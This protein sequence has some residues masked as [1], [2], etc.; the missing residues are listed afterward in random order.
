VR[1]RGRKEEKRKRRGGK[2]NQGKREGGRKG[3][4]NERSK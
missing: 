3:V 1:K 2:E 4:S